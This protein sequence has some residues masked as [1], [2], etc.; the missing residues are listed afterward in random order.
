[1]TELPLIARHQTVTMSSPLSSPSI[2]SPS[3][4]DSFFFFLYRCIVGS[5]P[6]LPAGPPYVP[7]YESHVT[8]PGPAR[9]CVH[10]S[11]ERGRGRGSNT[12]HPP[13]RAPGRA[14]AY[15]QGCKCIGKGYRVYAFIPKCRFQLLFSMFANSNINFQSKKNY[16]CF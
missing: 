8:P 15:A 3:R 11:T 4:A 13:L 10:M 1:M 9:V 2:P 7:P 5:R 14:R 6:Q 16:L 12:V